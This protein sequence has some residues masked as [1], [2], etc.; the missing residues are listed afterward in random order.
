MGNIDSDSRV[1]K[2]L[3]FWDRNQSSILFWVFAPL[4]F[5][6]IQIMCSYGLTFLAWLI[7]LP[8]GKLP[9]PFMV[10]V[11]YAVLAASVLVAIYS[12]AKLWRWWKLR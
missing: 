11:T 8:F 2:L 6:V 3:S 5:L 4:V 7:L 10:A 1:R 12:V 9:Q